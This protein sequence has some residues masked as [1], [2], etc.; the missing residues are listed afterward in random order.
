MLGS[1]T[2]RGGS[3]ADGV[4]VTGDELMG[5][6]YGFSKGQTVTAVS[7]SPSVT[8]EGSS[9][10]IQGS[11]MDQSPAQ[12][13]T[14]AISDDYMSEWMNY[15]HM[16]QPLPTD[17]AGVEVIID[18]I[19]SNNNYR[20]IGTATSDQSGFYSLAWAPDITGKFTVIATFAGSKSYYASYAETAFVVDN[21]PEAPATPEYPVVP[22]NTVLL[23]GILGGVIAAIVIG[24]AAVLISMRK[25]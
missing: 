8:T 24:I 22:D 2:T 15:L 16:Q 25:R 7:A 9:V 18:V 23:Y 20:N 13:N 14:P 11:V 1:L 19:D 17:A 6:E 10:L 5:F 12:P 3:I 4:L 21:A